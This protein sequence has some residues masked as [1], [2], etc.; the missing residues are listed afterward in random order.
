MARF[1]SARS[2]AAW[3]PHLRSLPLTDTHRHRLPAFPVYQPIR[4]V[5]VLDPFAGSGSTLVAAAEMNRRYV[6]IEI[7]H[8]YWQAARQRLAEGREGKPA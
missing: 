6:G 1:I 7:S 3:G 2:D 8:D 5:I 4:S